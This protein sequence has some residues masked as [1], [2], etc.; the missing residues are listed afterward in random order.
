[1]SASK[2]K[3]LQASNKHMDLNQSTFLY[4]SVYG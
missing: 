2:Q 1:M 4:K 3:T